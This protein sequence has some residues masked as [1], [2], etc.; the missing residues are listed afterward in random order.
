MHRTILTNRSDTM[1]DVFE[2]FVPVLYR[3]QASIVTV[4][5]YRS[6]YF[7]C[8]TQKVS[9]IVL[10]SQR[11]QTYFRSSIASLCPGGGG[12]GRGHSHIK[13]IGMVVSLRGVNCRFWSHLVSLGL[14]VTIF[15]H[16]GIA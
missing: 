15:A 11:T 3:S 10:P 12:R 14:K 5:T 6:R 16:S 7:S 8:G 2:L 13:V 4:H 9:G 1:V